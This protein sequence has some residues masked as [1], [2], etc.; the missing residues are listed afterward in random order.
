MCV[1]GCIESV[2]RRRGR[3]DFISGAGMMAVGAA[4]LTARLLPERAA[5]ARS[6]A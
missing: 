6:R 3:R 5:E 1:P 4:A 2:H